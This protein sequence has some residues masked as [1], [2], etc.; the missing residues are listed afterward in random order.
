MPMTPAAYRSP[1]LASGRCS[2]HAAICSGV[3]S[4]PSWPVKPTGG[5]FLARAGST[6]GAPRPDAAMASAATAKGEE[7][8]VTDTGTSFVDHGDGQSPSGAV[9]LVVFGRTLRRWTDGD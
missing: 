7:I 4:T 8:E 1:T 2:L 5:N 3:G 6:T 9:A